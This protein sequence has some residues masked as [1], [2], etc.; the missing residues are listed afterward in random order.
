M[1]IT[2]K[3]QCGQTLTKKCNSLNDESKAKYKDELIG[4]SIMG[5]NGDMVK[6]SDVVFSDGDIR[7][8][9][10]EYS[11]LTDAGGHGRYSMEIKAS[12]V[13]DAEKQL[14]FIDNNVFDVTHTP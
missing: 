11:S 7:E 9:I 1:I 14:R 13:E 8:F 4:A 12:S 2:V 10:L 6:V 3:T 5:P